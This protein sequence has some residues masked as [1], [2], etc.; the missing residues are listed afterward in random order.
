MTIRSLILIL[1]IAL[2]IEAG[3]SSDPDEYISTTEL[4][5][6]KGYPCEE[7]D[8]L[9]KDGYILRA[10]RIPHGVKA[11]TEP[12]VR[13]SI[14]LMHGLFDASS[15]W[16]LNFPEQSLGFILADRGFDVWLGKH[17]YLGTFLLSKLKHQI[18]LLYRQHPRQCLL[19]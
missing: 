6:N 13:P 4:I 18:N 10:H 12:G 1:V 19:E 17:E 3:L 16:V 5:R 14:I 9:T 2:S 11:F 7:H 8:I 15:D